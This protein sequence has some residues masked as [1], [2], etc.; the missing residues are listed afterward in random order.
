M[1]Q[2]SGYLT[3]W[4]RASTRRTRAGWRTC[5][6]S[7]ASPGSTPSGSRPAAE[8]ATR[9]RRR[10]L[11]G[12]LEQVALVADADQVPVAT[13]PTTPGVVTLM[14]LHTAKGLEFPVVFLTGLEDGVFPHLRS[15]G[16]Q[17][18]AGGGAPA[19]VRRHH[20]GP[21]AALPV[22]RGHP[23]GVGA[24]AVQPALAVPGRAAAPSWSGWERTEAAYTSGPA[25]GG[26]GG[27][28]GGD[29][30]ERGF[31]GGTPKAAEL[32]PGSAS[33]RPAS[34]PPASCRRRP[35]S[36][37]RRP[38]QPPALRAGP[39]A[40]GRG[41]RR[42]G[43]GPDRLRRPGDVDGAAARPDREALADRGCGRRI[44]RADLPG[45]SAG[46]GD[47]QPTSRRGPQPRGRVDLVPHA[48]VHLEVQVGAGG[49]AGGALAAR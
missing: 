3:S 47:Q 22:P 38:G 15:L 42:P 20:P 49:V 43:P 26:V 46:D 30:R 9:S 48:L 40:R 31:V 39:G 34:P 17:Q 27:R 24:A 2:R 33:T 5:R 10:R 4:R 11:A 14:T 16:D 21:A 41:A 25:G 36:G 1:L 8:E 45:R 35:R 6:S 44:S 29:R 23:L 32:A 18:R 28:G 19:G 13:T 12:F 37:G 7:S